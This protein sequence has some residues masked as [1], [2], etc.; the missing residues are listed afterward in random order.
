M[1]FSRLEIRRVS[2]LVLDMI[3]SVNWI[4]KAGVRNKIEVMRIDF[5]GV[6][7]AQQTVDAVQRLHLDRLVT[8][9]QAPHFIIKA[10]ADIAINHHRLRSGPAFMSFESLIQGLFQFLVIG[11]KFFVQKNHFRIDLAQGNQGIDFFLHNPASD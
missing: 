6:P 9:Q 10:Q 7:S 4:L 3:L 2:S 11:M 1:P 8:F 5:P